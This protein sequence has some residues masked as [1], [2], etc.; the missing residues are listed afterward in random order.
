MAAEEKPT[1]TK[2]LINNPRD[3]VGE[4]LEGVVAANPGLNVLK[5]HCVIIR[6]DVEEL[7]KEGKV[8][9]ISGG[10]SGHE[11]AHAGF[12]G[13]GMLT[14]AVAG[15][16]FTSP[17]TKSILAAIRAVGKENG[18][19]TLLIVK[20]YT[21]DRLNF[22]FAAE[23]AKAEGM[24]VEMVVVGE[25]CALTSKDKTAGR[26]GLCGTILIH[27][28]AG[29]LAEEGKS[30]EEILQVVKTAAKAMG[31]IGVSLGPCSV[32]GSLPSFVLGSDE[33]ELGL[34]IHGEPG[35]KRVKMD[36]A[37]Q[38]VQ[39]MVNHMCDIQSGAAHKLSLKSGDSVA[40]VVNNLGGTSVL[41]LNI[42]A[43][44]AIKYLTKQKG[45]SVDR[46]YTGSFMTSL[47]MAGVSITILHL[48]ETRSRCLDQTTTAPAWPRVSVS[49]S[50]GFLTTE[51]EPLEVDEGTEGKEK[52]IK[53]DK[54]TVLGDKVYNVLL[55]ITDALV[56]AEAELNELDNRVGDGDCGST[57]ARGA[58]GVKQAM[59]S[60]DNP[61]LPYNNPAE[62]L[63]C[64]A[65]LC[66]DHMGGSSGVFYSLLLTSGAVHLKTN[67]DSD[68]GT[69][70]QALNAGIQ[71]I[72]RYGG[73]EP[74]DRTMLDALHP[75]ESTLTSSL[76][77]GK[78]P[79]EAL[80]EAVEASEQG[81]QSTSAMVARA[82][83]SSYV[84]VD[85]LNCVDPG[86]LAVSIWLRA[87]FKG[88]K[89]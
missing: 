34:G 76:A 89:N 82:G 12:V 5:G 20:N 15:A 9:L 78:Q 29:A 7:R 38:V 65:G 37:D 24:K 26:R 87:A 60:H 79:L 67:S 77:A 49:P 48:D 8:T 14:A 55:H 80:Q 21:G 43:G 32:P 31:T 70:A 51:K 74:G 50:T 4:A 62:L 19:G 56:A 44:A 58:K 16:V 59:G 36:Q 54:L 57:L 64:L 61:C 10:G 73:A 2:K 17:P 40:L 1:V 45:I 13:K 84:N 28:I 66:E 52:E 11:P 83:R 41:E 27:K 23:R 63:L 46:V 88:L 86:A 72:M 3:V 68:A 39:T 22:G 85:R 75:A 25:D 47:E 6:E 18:A 69:W 35:V 33:M 53:C 42:V 71:S 30:L 81:A